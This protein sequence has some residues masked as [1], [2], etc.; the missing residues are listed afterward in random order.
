PVVLIGGGTGLAPLQAIARTMLARGFASPVKLY[1]GVRAERDVYN[2]D[3]F[4]ALAKQHPNFSYEIVLS[5]ASDGARRKGFVHLAAAADLASVTGYKAYL[6]GPP[7]MVEAATEM[8]KAKGLAARDIHADAY[9][10][11]P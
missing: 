2:E 10:D 1:F 6:A 4:A 3:R 7:I 9:Y 8:L 5:E 11:Q